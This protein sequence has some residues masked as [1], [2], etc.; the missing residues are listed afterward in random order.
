MCVC[1]Y[2]CMDV[3]MYIYMYVCIVVR[4]CF[5]IGF[6]NPKPK[7]FHLIWGPRASPGARGKGVDAETSQG[8]PEIVDVD[9]MRNRWPTSLITVATGIELLTTGIGLLRY[10]WS[11]CDTGGSVVPVVVDVANN[12]ENK[13]RRKRPVGLE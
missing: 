7:L 2:V 6:V 11:K 3:C 12:T 9:R 10:R 5:R 13:N 4:Y 1:V 8:R